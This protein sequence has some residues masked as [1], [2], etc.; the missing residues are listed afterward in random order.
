MSTSTERFSSLAIFLHWSIALGIILNILLAWI[1]PFM[2]DDGFASL[3]TVHKSIGITIF[4]LAVMRLIWRLAHHPPRSPDGYQRWEIAASHITHTM[5]YAVMFIMP[6]T[7]W[8]TDSAWA[9]AANH[10]MHYFFAFEWPR[11]SFIRA[12]A[13]EIKEK[14]FQDSMTI[15]NYTSYLI[16]VLL[17]LHICGALKHQLFDGERALQRMWFR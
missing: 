4:G 15:H 7:G 9:D 13:P 17:F 6:L 12:L 16:Y 2:S 11:I 1:W 5:L 14:V 8:I 3:L 10:P